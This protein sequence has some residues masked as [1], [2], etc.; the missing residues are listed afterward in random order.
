V[1]LSRRSQ[2]RRRACSCCPIAGV[3]AALPVS[4]LARARS[5]YVDTLGL[6]PLIEGEDVLQLEEF[7]I[8]GATVND[9]VEGWPPR[10]DRGLG[11]ELS[12]GANQQLRGTSDFAP[13]GRARQGRGMDASAD[14]HPIRSGESR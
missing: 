9:G 5:F 6:T 4:D 12:S 10:V 11:V 2:G 13:F 1:R 14:D 8:P 3:S 7:D